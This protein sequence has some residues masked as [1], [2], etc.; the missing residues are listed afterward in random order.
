MLSSQRLW[1]ASWSRLLASMSSSFRRERGRIVVEEVTDAV[2]GHV[3]GGIVA[4][5]GLASVVALARKDGRQ[6]RA[7]VT[8]HRREDA[9]LVVDQHVV[10]RGEAVLDV[11]ELL[12]LVDVDQHPAVD[13]VE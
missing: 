4:D 5:V 12:F 13:R 1:P 10:R 11:V 9:D 2:D 3:G 8:L 6:A 7:P